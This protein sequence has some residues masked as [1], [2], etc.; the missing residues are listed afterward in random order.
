M[1]IVGSG[2]HGVSG[3]MLCYAKA[4]VSVDAGQSQHSGKTGMQSAHRTV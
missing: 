3:K 4:L 2:E 1:T